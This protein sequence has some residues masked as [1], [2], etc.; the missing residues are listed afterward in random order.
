MPVVSLSTAEQNAWDHLKAQTAYGTPPP[1]A[2]DSSKLRA[3]DEIRPL[4][5]SL[6]K[7]KAGIEASVDEDGAAAAAPVQ[8]V[9]GHVG[10]VTLTTMDIG[11]FGAA[12]AAAAP[13]QSVAGR[14]S[15]V[16]LTY[17][18]I[19][20]LGAA[21][22][23]AVGVSVGNLVEIQSDGKILSSILPAIAITE[24]FVV[25]SQAAM[26][27]LTAERGDVAIRTDSSETYI[28]GTDDPTQLG[29]WSLILSPTGAV[30]SVNSRIGAV[31]IVTADVQELLAVTDLTTYAS[32][33]GTGTVAIRST[34]TS[35]TTN[36]VLTWSG[37]NW[38]NQAPVSPYSKLVQSGTNGGTL[39]L[40]DSTASTGQTSLVVQNGPG[41]QDQDSVFI[42]KAHNGTPLFRVAHRTGGNYGSVSAIEFADPN[43]QDWALGSQGGEY[44][45]G[46]TLGGGSAIT[47]T[48]QNAVYPAGIG[49]QYQ[50]ITW[51][52]TL[53]G[54]TK[55]VASGAPT[56]FVRIA[57][58]AG[59]MVGGD[60]E[61]T[62]TATDGTDHQTLQGT[63][64]F[65]VAN[66]AGAE[67]ATLGTKTETPAACS[68]GTLAASS[69]S[70]FTT[71]T[72]PTNAVD[73]AVDFTSS[74]AGAAVKIVWYVKIKSS[75]GGGPSVTPI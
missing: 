24:R 10:V 1:G 54:V 21:A 72:A 31:T 17:A 44:K 9:A 67:T 12:A 70:G 23:R 22:Q 49:N 25:A 19:G 33:S 41:A 56:A 58:A 61:Y 16:T 20:G 8:S 75:V 15:A 53:R 18:D 40:R 65:S 28:L 39:T 50:E 7:L 43:L 51:Y 68:T 64:G 4:G 34:I 3:I 5:T 2:P 47:L 42:V 59:G 29:N 38:I 32:V 69:G 48:D 57:C 37:T 26:L 71:S 11:G 63:I 73:I 55:T 27:A 52:R 30:S 14:T 62:I 45:R 66:K 6:E 46:M 36:D 74:L 60:V 13:V 35:P